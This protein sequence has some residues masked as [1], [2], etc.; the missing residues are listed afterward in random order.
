ME[1]QRYPPMPASPAKPLAL[2]PHLA[3]PYTK[4]LV[5]PFPE[6]SFL[7]GTWANKGIV[8]NLKCF[9]H[10]R[11]MKKQTECWCH[12]CARIRDGQGWWGDLSW[13]E[14]SPAHQAVWWAGISKYWRAMLFVTGTYYFV[15]AKNSFSI[16][17]KLVFITKVRLHF[18]K[19]MLIYHIS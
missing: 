7:N 15:L 14:G 18:G 19:N 2:T 8:K 16:N 6:H 11:T 5:F 13:R 9:H 17:L 1:G 10:M 3:A 4:Q 12:R